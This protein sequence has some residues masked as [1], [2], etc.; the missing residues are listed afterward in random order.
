VK[1][2]LVSEQMRTVGALE[3]FV[4]D[5]VN[6]SRFD[7]VVPVERKGTAL[8]RAALGP[9]DASK[10]RRILSSDAVGAAKMDS[11][12]PARIL[13]FDDSVWTG[14]SLLS[15]V[16][17]V[18]RMLP[19]CEVTT[20][21]FVTHQNAPKGIIDVAYYRGVDDHCYRECRAALVDY[22]QTKGSLLLDTEHLEITARVAGSPSA[23]Y[24][25][26]AGWGDTVI[27]ASGDRTNC[28]VNRRAESLAAAFE[29][30]RPLYADLT[31]AICKVRVV[32]RPEERNAY[33]I[34]P[35][36]FPQLR[37]GDSARYENPYMP[38]TSS[39]VWNQDEPSPR[40]FQ[41]IGLGFSLELGLDVMSYLG[42]SLPDGI[43][44]GFAADGID[45]LLAMFPEIDLGQV[46]ARLNHINSHRR[47]RRTK[48]GVPDDPGLEILEKLASE[49]LM[50]CFD[51]WSYGTGFMKQITLSDTLEL[52]RLTGQPEVRI[53]A[54]LDL[55]IDSARIL[56]QVAYEKSGDRTLV[57]RAFSPEGEVVKRKV[58]RRA[59]S[60]G[61]GLELAAG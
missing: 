27:F 23:F 38:W 16:E 36:C 29:Q 2:I 57:K 47:A 32:S 39:I 19:V 48:P 34:I 45:H 50:L 54:A 31:G 56:P 4:F 60:M 58:V 15:T 46:R 37:L 11:Q 17:A 8:I 5:L 28:T 30:V 49:I 44:F 22:L 24:E 51:R 35:I 41:S 21:A 53:S 26:L 43:E 6:D 42:D 12:R 59:L 13:V 18:R 14:H 7:F 9:S 10:W 20:A 25:A 3:Q 1:Q 40:L 33:S 55:L 61:R 52:S